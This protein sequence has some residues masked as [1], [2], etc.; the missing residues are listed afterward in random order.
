MAHTPRSLPE[1]C[2]L[3]KVETLLAE[4]PLYNAMFILKKHGGCYWVQYKNADDG[5]GIFCYDNLREAYALYKNPNSKPKGLN[6]LK[7][8]ENK[9]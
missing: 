3:A 7:E 8:N 6:S 9:V 5:H 1:E 4:K 2:D